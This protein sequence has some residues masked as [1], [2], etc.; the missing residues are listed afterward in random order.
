M[1]MT[2]SSRDSKNSGI[3]SVAPTTTMGIF[4]LVIVSKDKVLRTASTMARL[5]RSKNTASAQPSHQRPPITIA[6]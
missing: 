5:D 4:L 1:D 2:N 3:H 6:G